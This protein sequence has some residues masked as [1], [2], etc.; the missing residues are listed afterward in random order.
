M[1]SRLVVGLCA[2]LLL[3][4]TYYVEGILDGDYELPAE[5]TQGPEA[6]SWLRQ[7]Q[8]ESALASN[9]FA[10]TQNAV[11]FVKRLYE[12]GAPR[13]IVPQPVIQTDQVESYADALVVSLPADPSKRNRVWKI[14]AEELRRI[15]E[16][17]DDS[18][19]EDRVLLRWD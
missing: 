6:L 1:N 13:V 2:G 4:G 7:N 3:L 15:G 10:E 8:G 18:P 5:Y 14:C 19:V 11:R 17:P 9:R 16:S 12:A